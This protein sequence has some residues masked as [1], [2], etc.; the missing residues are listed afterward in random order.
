MTN[1]LVT[2]K[3]QVDVHTTLVREAPVLEWHDADGDHAFTVATA[4]VVGSAEESQLRIADRRVS[5]THASLELRDGTLW[6][7]D[8]GSLNGCFV[9]GLR[10]IE[11]EVP[12]GAKLQL[13][14]IALR[15]GSTERREIPLWP[16][17][18]FGGLVG[19]SV[20]MRE[21][22]QRLSNYA[23]SKAAVMV[24]GPCSPLSASST[25]SP[26][27]APG[28]R[29]GVRG[30]NCSLRFPSAM[31]STCPSSRTRTTSR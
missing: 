1:P 31:T 29:V 3:Q 26:G 6:V 22:F 9:N 13:G 20:V 7:R 2:E 5:R 12:W 19:Q 30:P 4:V 23:P 16:H 21:L 27:A 14:P 24:R 15:L 8:L 28:G 10:V 25:V 11:S 18:R 17:N